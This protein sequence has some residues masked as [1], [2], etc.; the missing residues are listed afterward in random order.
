MRLI[1]LNP[2][3][4]SITDHIGKHVLGE[5]L[6]TGVPRV[7]SGRRKFV[8]TTAGNPAWRRSGADKERGDDDK[9][10]REGPRAAGAG[11]AA[12]AGQR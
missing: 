6:S 10:W 7:G 3:L 9:T 2:G 5:Y 11:H 12:G 8:D 4:T 1:E